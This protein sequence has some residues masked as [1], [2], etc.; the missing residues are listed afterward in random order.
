M[1]LCATA[2]QAEVFGI[3]PGSFNATASTTQAGAHPDV[4]VRFSLREA[5]GNPYA[6]AGV[7][8][9][10]VVDLPPGLVG[11]PSAAPR[12]ARVQ[13]PACPIETQVGSVT[14]NTGLVPTIVAPVFNVV[15]SHGAPAE[16]AFRAFLVTIRLQVSVRPDGGLRTTIAGLPTI[17]PLLMN[18]LTFWGVPGRRRSHDGDRWR[19][20][21]GLSSLDPA[22]I[23]PSA[24]GI[25]G[26]GPDAG[27][28]ASPGPRK[29][30]MTNGTHL[31]GARH[32]QA[33]GRELGSP[34]RVGARGGRS[35]RSRP[36][37]TD[38]PSRRAAPPP[39]TPPRPARRRR[40]RSRCR[41]RSRTIPTRSRRRRCGAPW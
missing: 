39:S 28:H 40:G 7:A 11:D 21:A 32:R 38:R 6:A 25:F 17:A 13:F 22:D 18:Q 23:D 8:Q 29:A 41:S 36:A 3:K 30:F 14:L 1:L 5:D 26:D 31:R 4:T 15:P 34:R 33:G 37:A 16:F 12:C 35:C 19:E 20:C 2:A 27:G 24:C 9:T 10:V